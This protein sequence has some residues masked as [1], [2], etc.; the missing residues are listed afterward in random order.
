MIGILLSIVFHLTNLWIFNFGYGGEIGIFPFLMIASNLLF[1][2]PKLLRN[3]FN[4]WFPSEKKTVKAALDS[5]LSND[6][7]FNK[8]VL[9]FVYLYILIQLILPFRHYLSPAH[10]DWTG[11]GQYF[12]WR[13]KIYS[14]TVQ[15]KFTARRFPEDKPVTVQLQK[16]LN[17]IQV[18]MMGQHAD[19]V[20]KTVQY[21]VHDLESRLK[22]KDPIINA[23]IMVSYNGR[24]F[25]YFIDPN[26]NLAKVTYNP[27]SNNSWVMP[28]PE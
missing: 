7:R 27:Y 19:M 10:V 17:T 14:K 16:M 12:A 11:Q 1:L 4:K 15:I 5:N 20:Y 3:Y 18:N 28:K 13:M 24:P 25:V 9:S 23:E 21:I 6:W 22:I 26:V 8:K 2:D